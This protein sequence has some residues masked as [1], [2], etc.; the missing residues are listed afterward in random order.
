MGRRIEALA[1]MAQRASAAVLAP[2]VLI[3]L[4]LIIYATQSGLSAASILARTRGSLLWGGF[5]GLFV[6]ALSVHASIGLR[7]VLAEWLNWR[8]ARLRAATASVAA[9]ILLLGLRAVLAVVS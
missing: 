4:I 2:F 9:L 3:H 1:F 7:A 8:G 6:L 5:Y